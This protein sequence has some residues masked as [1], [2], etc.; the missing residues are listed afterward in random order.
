[1]KK[2]ILL[3]SFMVMIVLILVACDNKAHSLNGSYTVSTMG[4][5]TTYTFD[6]DGNAEVK[7]EYSGYIAVDQKGT[8]VLNED[9][10]EITLTF[11]EIDKTIGDFIYTIPAYDGTFTFSQD[12]TSITIGNIKYTVEYK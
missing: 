1:M 7:I 4:I 2:K 8:Y 12:D 10:T 6:K 9:K 3:I 11:P 5:D